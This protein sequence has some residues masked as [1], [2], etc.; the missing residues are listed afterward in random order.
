METRTVDQTKIFKLVLNDMRADKAS[1]G[2]LTPHISYDKS[3][4]CEY[5]GLEMADDFWQDEVDG[6]SYNKRFKRG[7]PLEYYNHPVELMGSE[8]SFGHGV[9]S[10]WIDS[11]QLDHLIKTNRLKLV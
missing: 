11:A 7:S 4:L 6:V 5:V 2:T 8:N 9:S 1:E 10:E 3:S